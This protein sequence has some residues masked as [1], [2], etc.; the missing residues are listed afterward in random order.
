MLVHLGPM[1]FDM[2]L[3]T[4]QWYVS[5]VKGTSAYQ[6]DTANNATVKV[7]EN[8]KEKAALK[9]VASKA[10]SM[11]YGSSPPTPTMLTQEIC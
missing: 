9:R 7:L 1:Q 3:W 10:D 11:G 5:E 4:A 2:Q 8:A 6:H